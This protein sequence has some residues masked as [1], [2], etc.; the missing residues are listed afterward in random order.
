[1]PM[2]FY[3]NSEN[4]Y[5]Q[6]YYKGSYYYAE[7]DPYSDKDH[8]SIRSCITSEIVLDIP[9]PE[10]FKKMPDECFQDQ[11]LFEEY[12]EEDSNE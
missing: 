3:S 11:A 6:F 5:N 1:M 2:S 9:A 10:I 7:Y 8:I 4:Y 12:L